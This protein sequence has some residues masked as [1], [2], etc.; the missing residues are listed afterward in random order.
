MKKNPTALALKVVFGNSFE[1]DRSMKAQQ[2]GFN[3]FSV[4]G[5]EMGHNH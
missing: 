4:P 2:W 3:S 5:N 1:A